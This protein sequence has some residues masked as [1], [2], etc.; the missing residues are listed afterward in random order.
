VFAQAA[1]VKTDGGDARFRLVLGRVHACGLRAGGDAFEL[2]ACALL[3]AGALL[4]D[5]QNTRNSR[6]QL[7]PWLGAGL[8]LLA[9]ARIAGPLAL[10]V[11]GAGR[12]LAVHDDFAF[13]PQFAA[14]QVP[15]FAWDLQ[16]GLS[17]RAW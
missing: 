16:V 2:R 5:G 14:H 1:T 4:A 8:G 6:S 15:V 10:E 17:Y 3:E 7:M 11:G 12:A 13:S 9:A